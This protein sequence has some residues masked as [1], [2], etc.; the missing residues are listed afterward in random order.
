MF[1]LEI[2][3][4]KQSASRDRRRKALIPTCLY[5]LTHVG[6]QKFSSFLSIVSF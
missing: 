5:V 1:I 3:R 4:S 6:P 2:F